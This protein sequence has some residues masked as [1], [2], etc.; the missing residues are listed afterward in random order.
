MKQTRQIFLPFLVL[1]CATA[2]AQ[3][4]YDIK[5]AYYGDKPD[6][7]AT[8]SAKREKKEEK[9]SDNGILTGFTG[10]M[11][12]H[13]GY[14]FAQSPDE[15][16]RNGSLAGDEGLSNLPKDGVILGIGG[17]LRVHLINHIHVG[18]EG[19]VSTMPL[20]KS[21]SNARTG[22]GGAICDFYGTVGKV[23]L[24]IGGLIGGGSTHRL[25]VPD[26]EV[27][28]SGEGITYNAS[29]TKTPF[30]LLDPYVGLEFEL[31]N[32]AN[33]LIKADY[34]LPFGKGNNGLTTETVRWSNFIS[35]SGPR[36]YVGVMFGH[37]KRR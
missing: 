37:H 12:L 36:L 15:L 35:P 29:Y 34:M 33:L 23:Q 30:F 18:A 8:A 17:A 32:H 9:K 4:V 27:Q 1:L 21:G 26:N 5:T 20:M 25:F 28:V 13:A 14:G 22:W 31:G 16:F 3:N 19:G 24:F 11:M 10:G 7:E 2:T 6:K